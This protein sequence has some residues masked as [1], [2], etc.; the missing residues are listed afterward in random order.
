MNRLEQALQ[1]VP[2]CEDV[3]LPFLDWCDDETAASGLPETF[4]LD[5]FTKTDGSSVRNPLYSYTFGAGVYDSLSTLPDTDYSK[6][7]GYE[8]KRYPLSGLVGVSDE[9]RATT[10]AYNKSF[11]AGRATKMLNDNAKA[12]LTLGSEQGSDPVANTLGTREKFKDCLNAPNY[13]V[14]SNKSSA[15]QYNQELVGKWKHTGEAPDLVVPLESPHN[16][17]HLA[18]GGYNVPTPGPGPP[19]PVAGSA[20]GDM[21]R[22]LMKLLPNA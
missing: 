17:M 13:T 19:Q 12:W 16:D 1:S 9:Q 15:S 6:P 3:M 2:G 4:T 7:V 5:R 22:G 21:V 18:M 10:E 8:T 14:F 11:T 20:N